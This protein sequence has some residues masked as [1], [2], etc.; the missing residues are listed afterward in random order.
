LA[1][2]GTLHSQNGDLYLQN[3]IA[4]TTHLIA[5]SSVHFQFFEANVRFNNRQRL[6][7]R[8]YLIQS[9]FNAAMGFFSSTTTTPSPFVF[10]AGADMHDKDI[11][12][13][14]DYDTEPNTS[15]DD[16]ELESFFEV[17]RVAHS[18]LA[19]FQAG[20]TYMSDDNH[21][22]DESS[23]VLSVATEKMENKST[24][25]T[26]TV[27]GA[28]RRPSS[29]RNLTTRLKSMTRNKRRHLLEM[30]SRSTSSDQREEAVC[31]TNH[32]QSVQN[33]LHSDMVYVA[34]S[35]KLDIHTRFLL[36]EY[37]AKSLEEI[38]LLGEDEWKELRFQV[39]AN[40]IG[41][42]AELYKIIALKEWI[43]HLVG[44][45]NDDGTIPRDWK[46]QFQRALPELKEKVRRENHQGVRESLFS[47]ILPSSFGAFI[48]SF[49]QCGM[50]SEQDSG[51]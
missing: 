5:I 33:S 9:D 12:K 23:A 34:N 14:L 35:L 16:D 11:E 6:I 40:T 22:F 44:K 45:D 38:S 25:T 17:N 28:S 39:Q 30:E 7:T 1:R 49:A 48:R 41:S 3:R 42:N 26:R 29:T 46:R 43:Q 18:N 36:A 47:A 32:R 24:R 4:S 15:S 13:A 2:A 19:C 20:T 27:E 50:G 8:I 51:F 37:N 21:S 10:G 31:T